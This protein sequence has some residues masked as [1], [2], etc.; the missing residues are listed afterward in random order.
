MDDLW[1]DE[2]SC[3]RRLFYDGKDLPLQKSE[4]LLVIMGIQREWLVL[5]AHSIS[6]QTHFGLN[7][8]PTYLISWV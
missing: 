2:D 3:W 8:A 6:Q 7:L 5:L 1:V 4:S